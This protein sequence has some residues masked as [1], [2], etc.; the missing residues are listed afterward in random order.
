LLTVAALAAS[1]TAPAA[2]APTPIDAIGWDLV[3]DKGTSVSLRDGCITLGA[4]DWRLEGRTKTGKTGRA[5]ATFTS[6]GPL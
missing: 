3:L 4:A 5:R 6:T 2:A 1:G